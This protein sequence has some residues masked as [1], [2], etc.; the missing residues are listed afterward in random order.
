MGATGEALGGE[1]GSLPASGNPHPCGLRSSLGACSLSLSQGS[2]VFMDRQ[3]SPLLLR[4]TACSASAQFLCSLF[5]KALGKAVYTCWLLAW[6]LP[7]SLFAGSSHL[8]PS[9]PLTLRHRSYKHASGISLRPGPSALSAPLLQLPAHLTSLQGCPEHHLAPTKP[10]TGN[11]PLPPKPASRRTPGTVPQCR[12]RTRALGVVPD[13]PS[14]S[15][16][17]PACQSRRG[18]LTWRT[19]GPCPCPPFLTFLGSSRK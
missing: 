2:S 14:P 9:C 10:V 19:L 18:G 4:S 13:S 16:L 15:P 7:S 8:R 5:T 3:P 11:S 6:P 17:P 1:R 12:L